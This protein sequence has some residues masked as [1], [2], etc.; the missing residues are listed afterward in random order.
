VGVGLCGG[1]EAPPF[2]GLRVSAAQAIFVESGEPKDHEV[3]ARN[4]AGAR[5][6]ASR[7]AAPQKLLL[8]SLVLCLFAV[9]PAR[10]PAAA[11]HGP[12]SASQAPGADVDAL[13]HTAQEALGRND[14]AAAAD[15]LKQAVAAQPNLTR[16]WFNLGYAYT[17][18]HKY[19]EAIAAYRK[20]VEL[21]PNLFEARLNLGILL[22]QRD[23]PQGALEH[24]EKAA[25]LKPDYLRAQLY[26]GWA[27]ARTGQMERAEKQ[28]KAVL[29]LDQK[30][31]TTHCDLGQLYLQEK[32]YQGALESFQK[33]YELDPTLAQAQMG[34]AWAAEGL[35]D[36]VNAAAHFEQFLAA[37]PDDLETRYHLARLYLEQGKNEQA[38]GELQT[39]YRVKPE[40][41]G[42]AAALG[43]VCALLKKFPESEKFYR[44]ALLT[45]PAEADLHRALGQA[46]LEQEKLSQAEAEF[47]SALKGNP[48]SREAAQG[49]ATSLYLQKRYPEAIPLLEA[50]TRASA[51]PPI[52]IFALASSYDN[53][54]VLQKALENYE[55]FLQLSNGHSPDHEWQAT[56]RAKLLRHQL[57]K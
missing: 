33:A 37:H 34:M 36:K 7:R 42:V 25:T 29:R 30:P 13:L 52:L 24:L 44:Q 56:Q 11:G 9:V 39:V 19:E 55:R 57:Q 4:D 28:Y 49:L 27:L 53:L 20:A 41:P 47:R 54:H 18:L 12:E 1:A 43:D 51:P 22:F 16:A 32:R 45:A 17:A 50:L 3:C 15:A 48:Q 35:N 5:Q 46:L 21:E 8:V 40:R 38:F 10:L 6:P 26:Y 23:N 31:A 2:Q 14:F